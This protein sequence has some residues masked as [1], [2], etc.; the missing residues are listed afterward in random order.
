MDVRGLG[1]FWFRDPHADAAAARHPAFAAARR[2]SAD[3][4][5]AQRHWAEGAS[6]A[7]M[8]EGERI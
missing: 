3:A 8:R 4:D 6:T 5:S 7:M 2:A 1:D